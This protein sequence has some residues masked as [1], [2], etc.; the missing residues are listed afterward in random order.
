M[1][2]DPIVYCLDRLTDYRQFERLASDLMAGAGYPEI[3]PLGGTGDG[4]RDALYVDRHDGKI[5]IFAYSVRSDWTAKLRSDCRRVAELG[6]P[7]DAIVFVSTQSMDVQQ[8]DKIRTE[9]LKQYNWSVDYYDIERIRVLLTGPLKSVIGNHPSIFVPPWF[10]RRGG[11]LVSHEQRDMIVIDHL[12]IDH[13]FSSWLFGRLSAAG[14]SV[15]CRG[16]APIAGE[17][18]DETIRLLVQQRAARYLPVLSSDAV[19]DRD[20]LSRVAVATA[21]GVRTIPCQASGL[22]EASLDRRLASIA[23]ARFDISWARGLASVIQ[24][25]ESD[26]VPKAFDR[27]T[28]ASIALSAYQPEPLLRPE[29]ENVYANVFRAYVPDSVF[30]YELA[31]SEIGEDPTLERRWASV[32]RGKRLFSFSAAPSDLSPRIRSVSRYAWRHYSERCGVNSEHLVKM[33]VK[34]S[35][36]VACYRAGFCWCNERLTFYL[37]EETPQKHRYQHVDGKATYVSLTGERSWGSGERKSKMRYQLGP[38]FRVTL[39]ANGSVWVVLRLYVRVTDSDHRPIA[40]SGIPSRRKRVTRSW[41]NRQWLQRTLCVMQLIATNG[42]DIHGRIVIGSGNE[43]VSVTVAPLSWLC[44]VSIDV[45]ALD[46]V[47]N[48]GAE[49]ATVRAADDESDEE[50]AE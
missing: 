4:G 50:E 28:G 13:A 18:V 42:P 5:S 33:L 45:L 37:R 39:D 35:L 46:R 36:F 40:P 8:K 7:T 9:I 29:P 17:N 41:W 24:Q 47:G 2:A 1:S 6:H 10:E 44:P 31:D 22:R 15:W 49:L 11:Q 19:L 12:A 3:E 16:I 25:L 27:P 20:F 38:V 26:G 23:A 48:F 34:R 21:G 32:K 14:Y 43:A 30:M